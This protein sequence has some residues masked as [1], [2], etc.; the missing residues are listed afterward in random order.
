MF[1]VN[2]EER[3][4]RYS[5]HQDSCHAEAHAARLHVEPMAGVIPP[6]SRFE[7]VVKN[8]VFLYIRPLHHKHP[9]PYIYL[10]SES[11]TYQLRVYART[12]RMEGIIRRDFEDCDVSSPCPSEVVP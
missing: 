10:Y 9:Y 8:Q 12:L 1:L 2:E 11:H 7:L 6:K 4:F 3:P 5:F